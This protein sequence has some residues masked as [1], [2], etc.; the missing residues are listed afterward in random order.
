[1]FSLKQLVKPLETKNEVVVCFAKMMGYYVH[2][3]VVKILK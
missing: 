3:T 2:F 1:M